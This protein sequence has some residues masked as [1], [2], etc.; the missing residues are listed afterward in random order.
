MRLGWIEH[1]SDAPKAPIIPLDHS[2]KTYVLLDKRLSK[3]CTFGSTI[4]LFY[5]EQYKEI[6][7]QL[8]LNIALTPNLIMEIDKYNLIVI[9]I[10]TNTILNNNQINKEFLTTLTSEVKELIKNNK[11]VV[12][13]SSGAIGFGKQKINCEGK[14]VNEQQGL[15]AVGQIELMKEY[16]K[17][18]ELFDITPAQIL[19][20]QKDLSEVDSL[21]NLKNTLDFLFSKN[22]VPIVN[23]NDVVATIELRQNGFFSDNDGL[24]SILA[25]KISAQLLVFITQ[26]GGI[27]DS[28]NNIIENITDLNKIEIFKEK[29]ELGR[30]GMES[31]IIAIKNAIKTCD[32]FV[33][34]ETNFRGFSK[35][36]AKGS[37]IKKILY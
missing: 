7:Q 8:F 15:A 31:K 27:L 6:D 17:R 14:S 20:S 24:A 4:K 23:E 35:G 1:P 37:F 18:F 25:E 34:G 5:L 22:I 2:P 3:K 21:E 10:G 11:K 19:I 30:G 16:V 9:K 29:S 28:K 36:S 13:V 12:I 32:C 33:T 26:S